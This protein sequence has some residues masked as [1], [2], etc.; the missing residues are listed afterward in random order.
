[1]YEKSN[2]VL[3][4]KIKSL[5]K[6]KNKIRI[7]VWFV[8]SFSSGKTT[9]C[10]LLCYGFS[11][12]KKL[13]NKR[14]NKEKKVWL[15]ASLFG[16]ISNIGLVNDN[17]CSGADVIP[18]KTSRSLSVVYCSRRTNIIL[19]D[20]A[21]FTNSWWDMFQKNSDVLFLVHLKHDDLESNKKLL[22]KRRQEK[23]GN[24]D[25]IIFEDRTLKNLQGQINRGK[26]MYEKADEFMRDGDYKIEI[27][28]T[29]DIHYI[30]YKIL[31]SLLQIIRDN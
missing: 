24:N 12:N 22:S 8:G 9:Q 17:Q 28:A 2:K 19:V 23:V 16:L 7:V 10:R 1:M 6:Q 5:L 11:K 13:I 27:N 29:K 20:G 25:E 30:Q 14:I 4:K 26:N 31:K 3:I 15:K 18:N 21:L